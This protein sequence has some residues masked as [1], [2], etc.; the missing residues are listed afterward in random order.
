M[1]ERQQVI[2]IGLD[3]A[4]FDVIKP[5]AM[6]GKLPTF[7]QLLQT[8]SYGEM[9]VQYP[10]GTAPNWSSFRTGVNPGNH[11]FY[12]FM[13]R[14]EGSYKIRPISPATRNRYGFWETLGLHGKR[15]GVVNVPT[16]Y[17]PSPVNGYMVTGMFTP[18]ERVDYTYPPEFKQEIKQAMPDYRV[19]YGDFFPGGVA[20]M[21][22]EQVKEAQHRFQLARY[23]LDHKDLDFLMLVIRGTDR[24]GH[25]GFRFLD[26]TH[27]D[28]DAD[29]IAKHGNPVL[30]YYT[31]LDEQLGQFLQGIP[32]ETVVLFM[33]DHGQRP[34]HTVLNVGNFLLDAGYLQV[35]K[36]LV[37]QLK[38]WLLKVGWSPRTVV[39]I[40]GALRMIRTLKRARNRGGETTH[41]LQST[42]F[43]SNA[44]I[45][46]S[47]TTAYLPTESGGAINVNLKGREPEGHVEPGE[48]YERIR[49]QI[50]RDLEALR[51]PKTGD[52][53][54]E[55]VFLSEELYHGRYFDHAPDI[56]IYPARR[57]S[58]IGGHNFPFWG[59]LSASFGLSGVHSKLGIFL[60]HGRHIRSSLVEGVNI[61]DLAPTILHLLDVPIPKSMEGR[62]LTEIFE[63]GSP[64]AAREVTYAEGD[65]G[66]Q[67]SQPNQYSADEEEALES[68]LRALGYLH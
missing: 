4:T 28:Y 34:L 10:C 48:E 62:V 50:V 29:E 15:V 11:G 2:V 54:I 53:I 46:W 27:P 24:M 14:V 55:R 31:A 51:D 16:T 22:A 43:F 65:E 9:Q 17:P 45:D 36:S 63:P 40:A 20:D 44:D 21:V 38:Y 32:P 42:L 19:N 7:A 23:M 61:I 66:D 6:E 52:P 18:N 39:K 64:F 35:K 49:R 67:A 59:L 37:S 25:D 58:F 47:R 60:C 5:W 30:N 3:G 13:D 33:S 26:P 1:S 57:Y 56:V 41:A 68:R 8:G 12:S